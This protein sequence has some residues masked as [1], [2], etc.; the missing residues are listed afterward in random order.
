VL[1]LRKYNGNKTAI[2]EVVWSRR[3]HHL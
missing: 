2:S 1:V 3:F